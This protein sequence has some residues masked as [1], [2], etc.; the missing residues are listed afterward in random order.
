M[1]G[2]QISHMPKKQLNRA[3]PKGFP[4][5]SADHPGGQ[6]NPST[7]WRHLGPGPQMGSRCISKSS[8]EKAPMFTS[9]FSSQSTSQFTIRL[10]LVFQSVY[11][12]FLGC[13]NMP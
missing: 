12:M 4:R 9:Q 8:Q 10:P 6:R 13:H 2:L 1:Q 3:L 7:S 5:V 11:P